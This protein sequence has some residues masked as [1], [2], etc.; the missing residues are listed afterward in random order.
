MDLTTQLILLGAVFL[1]ASIVMSAAVS[2][3]GAPL[4]LVFLVLGMLAGEEGPGGIRFDDVRAAHLVGTIALAIILFDGGLRTRAETF[5]VGLWP[6]LSLAT[7]GVIVTAVITGFFAAWALNLSLLQG[8]LIGAIVGSTDAAAVFSLL[9]VHGMEL[10]QRVGATLEIESGVNDPMAVFLTIALIELLA[11]GHTTVDVGML[12]DFIQEMT[13][14]AAIGVAAGYGLSWLIN[15]LNLVTGLY[16]LL[17]VAG[18][19]VTYGL[20]SALHSSGFLAIYLAGLVLGNRRLHAAQNILRVH[21]GLA[22]LA[23]IAMFLVLGLLVTPSALLDH[24]RAALG[25]ALVLMLLARPAA[26]WLSLLPFRFPKREQIYIAWVGLRGAVPIILA[27]FPLLV[28]LDN[29]RLYFNIAFFVVLVSLLVQGWTVAPVA[30]WLNLQVPGSRGAVQRVNLEVPGQYDQEFVGYRITA[31][32]DAAGQSPERL[33]LPDGARLLTV[34]RD[35]RS[36]APTGVKELAAGD[37]VYVM[38]PGTTVDALDKIFATAAQP[39]HLE[40]HH[41]FGDFVLNG[42]AR[43]GDVAAMYGFTIDS[44]IA[45]RTLGDYLRDVFNGRPVVGDRCRLDNV[46]LVVREMQG[47]LISIVGLRLVPT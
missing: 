36:C 29:A 31:D 21:D 8:L 4:L 17:A 6:A 42:D 9:H 44:E 23:Q 16:P 24:A 45:T 30:R 13:V 15:R 43:L 46:E 7:V 27:L 3:V 33:Y 10:K 2:R 11:A 32:A 19:L 22:W 40:E 26:V 5:R 34:I 28:G 1:L 37:Y 20:A 18:G 41:F 47:G 12:F 38:A 25:V 35:G 14:G 39:Q